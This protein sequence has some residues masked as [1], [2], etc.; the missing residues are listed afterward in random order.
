MLD[1]SRIKRNPNTIMVA[2]MTPEQIMEATPA[3]ISRISGMI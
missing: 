3:M 2:V 1:G